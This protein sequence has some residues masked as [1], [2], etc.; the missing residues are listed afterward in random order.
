MG[1]K[2]SY[3][4]PLPDID[5]FG[6]PDLF[7]IGA[8][9]ANLGHNVTTLKRLITLKIQS[10]R[11]E[12]N[13]NTWLELQR[14]VLEHS[15]EFKDEAEQ[16]ARGPEII[17][18]Y[19]QE[20]PSDAVVGDL[21]AKTALARMLQYNPH[22]NTYTLDLKVG[23][24][25]DPEL[26]PPGSHG[27]PGWMRTL[28]QALSQDMYAGVK[29]TFAVVEGSER[30][31][32]PVQAQFTQNYV[33]TN[34]AEREAAPK[35][36]RQPPAKVFAKVDDESPAFGPEAKEDWEHAMMA[37]VTTAMFLFENLHACLHIMCATGGAALW[38]ATPYFNDARGLAIPLKKN[39][40][41]T[42]DQVYDELW[43]PTHGVLVGELGD[44][45][46]EHL[47]YASRSTDVYQACNDLIIE[48]AV[49]AGR[50]VT[51]GPEAATAAIMQDLVLPNGVPEADAAMFAPGTLGE[52]AALATFG[53]AV[54]QASQA[55]GN[56]SMLR[57]LKEQYRR[58]GNG[59]GQDKDVLAP[60]ATVGATVAG[61]GIAGGVLHSQTMLT[62]VFF[63]PL[64]NVHGTKDKRTGFLTKADIDVLS[65]VFGTVANFNEDHTFG[66]FPDIG[67]S[68]RYRPA[69]D[70]FR[71]TID[72]LRG[73]LLAA[74]NAAKPAS[75]VAP[76]YYHPS[77]EA[78]RLGY[79]NT[80]TTY[81]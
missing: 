81:V 4:H 33:M 24:A 7:A 12:L 36:G 59:A 10:G 30:G 72:A 61:V 3:E 19:G 5:Y 54:E 32:V 1:S 48:M 58:M 66:E 14:L 68:N 69:V 13:Q 67:K 34:R 44:D 77:E 38:S 64:V 17:W 75:G 9:V 42:Q 55:E 74:H 23:D 8:L 31:L 27:Q 18:G 15:T 43:H 63:T 73:N 78:I 47:G 49:L 21:F 60:M 65:L 28:L 6:N 22:D 71:T 70:Q 79:H 45:K 41:F 57:K 76:I 16:D 80:S 53:H 40:F 11:L 37:A 25:A 39:V 52:V 26:S 51:D 56:T 46:S 29:V 35:A 62:R 50:V 2:L 20:F